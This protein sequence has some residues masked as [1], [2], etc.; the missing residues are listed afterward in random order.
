M[1]NKEEIINIT[2]KQ[3]DE[4]IEIH[5]RDNYIFGYELGL[6]MAK[7]FI[8]L[9]E[10]YDKDQILKLLDFQLEGVNKIKEKYEDQFANKDK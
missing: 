4:L 7:N 9:N 10:N 2:R 6:L 1:N 5:R 3:L 8:E